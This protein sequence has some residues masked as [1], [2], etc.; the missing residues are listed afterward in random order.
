M[1]QYMIF[2]L[3]SI[4]SKVLLWAVFP[5]RYDKSGATESL[6]QHEMYISSETGGVLVYFWCKDVAIELDRVVS[7]GEKI[8]R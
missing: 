6:V 7:A 1:K 8:L 5:M 4:T 3:L 2:Q